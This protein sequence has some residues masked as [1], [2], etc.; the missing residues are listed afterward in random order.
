MTREAS[1][2]GVQS[3][4]EDVRFGWRETSDETAE[5]LLDAMHADG[6]PGEGPCLFSSPDRTP[7][8]SGAISLETEDGGRVSM[9]GGLPPDLPWGYHR[10]TFAGGPERVLVHGPGRCYLPDHLRV[11]GWGVQLHS[12]WSRDSWG[13]G[14]LRD[15]ERFG[16][17][18]REQGAEVALLNP[19]HAPNPGPQ[20]SSPYFPSSRCLRNPIYLRVEDVPGATTGDL[21]LE[22]LAARARA[23]N[24]GDT[25]D[26]DAVYEAKMEALSSLFRSWPGAARFDTYIGGRGGVFAALCTYMALAASHGGGHRTWDDAYRHPASPAVA[27]WRDEHP[28]EVRFQMWLQWLLDEQSRDAGKGIGLI[29]DIAV[30]VDPWGAD[31][32]LWQEV[33][34]D[35][36]TVGA[37]PDGFSTTGQEWGL[38]PFD[39]WKLRAAAYEPFIALVRANLAHAA[40]ARID[41]VMGLFRLWW[42]PVGLPATE[43]A[44][45]TYPS[46]DL[47]DIVALE[48]HR[49]NAFVVGED[50]GT[51]QPE[52]REE[53]ARRDLM[54]YKLAYFEADAPEGYP[55]RALAAI[56]NHDLPTIAGVWDGSDLAE[57][58]RLGFETDDGEWERMRAGLARL[59]R[60]D[61][62]AEPAEVIA[63][64]HAR[65]ALAPS[66]VLIATLED[67]TGVSERV[68]VPGTLDDQRTNWS[69]RLPV[70]L[71]DLGDRTARLASVLERP[72]P[73]VQHDVSLPSVRLHVAE[74]G[75]GPLVVLL[76]GFPEFWRS[77]RFQIPALARAGHRVVA[78]DLRGFNLSDKPEGIGSYSIE[79]LCADVRHLIESYGETRASI[80]GHDWG[81]NLAW[82]FAMAYPDMVDRLGIVN[83]PHPSR[84]ADGAT[85]PRQLL[86]SWYVG[87]FQLPWLPEAALRHGDFRALRDLLRRS[88]GFTEEVIEEYVEAAR[89][90]NSLHY[91][92]NY[93]RSFLRRN[94]VTTLRDLSAIER[95]TLVVWGDRDHLIERDLAEPERR[96]VPDVRVEHLAEAGHWPHLDEPDVANRL[97]LEHL[98]GPG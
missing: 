30:G 17:M 3:G 55:E 8:L 61:E 4:Y 91:P 86:R 95:P 23:L 98:R 53:M 28:Q 49:A 46:E 31:A 16:R 7:D 92:I 69:R 57:M 12:L 93:Y 85:N 5:R 29:Q 84:F 47:L 22:A 74:A 59:A 73:V 68:N 67:A 87:F 36:V 20:P 41:H 13:I 42:I 37:P 77:W 27:R 24:A 18:A 14:D 21:D 82:F 96:W 11:W 51:V 6:V 19:L 90:S 40:G 66:R 88:P 1:A 45:V 34:A 43:G 80:I 33:F 15:L 79:E 32:W 63:G 81:A 71:E 72:P 65:L 62:D 64:A 26:R 39:P 54:S 58:K 9:A 50:L 25:I 83:M 48:S 97:L 44:Y 76:H 94:L 75:E 56:T 10:V 2:W 35:D 78:P 60:L 70:S 38:P 52:V 89:R